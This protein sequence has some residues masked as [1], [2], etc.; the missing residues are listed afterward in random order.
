[1]YTKWTKEIICNIHMF[2]VDR[3]G[4]LLCVHGRNK[5]V[6]RLVAERS[7]PVS[8]APSSLTEKMPP[9]NSENMWAATDTKKLCNARLRSLN[10]RGIYGRVTFGPTRN[11][12][13]LLTILPCI[14]HLARHAGT[15][16]SWSR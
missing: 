11:R 10:R 4:V 15:H 16:I 13:Q 3:S 5:K 7:R 2:S 1:M 12:Q 8:S 9:R 6:G 14:R